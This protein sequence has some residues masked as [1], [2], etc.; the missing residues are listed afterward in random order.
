VT[1]SAVSPAETAAP[2]AALLPARRGV[3]W[4]VGP[5]PYD[6][7]P[8]AATSRLTNGRHALFVVEQAGRIEVFADRPDLFPVTPDAV[9]DATDPA[10]VV[11]L[12]ARVLRSVLPDLGPRACKRGCMRSQAIAAAVL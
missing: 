9:V 6:I 2:L 4:T 10:A 8:N 3:V 1:L 12:A 11:T 5:A 7:R